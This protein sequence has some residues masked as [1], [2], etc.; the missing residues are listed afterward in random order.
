VGLRARSCSP[1][2]ALA[3]AARRCATRT[4]GSDRASIPL[5]AFD[6]RAIGCDS[7]FH[8]NRARSSSRLPRRI[9]TSFA[10]LFVRCLRLARLPRERLEV[11]FARSTGVRC[12]FV[13]LTLRPLMSRHARA[14]AICFFPRAKTRSS[15]KT[16]GERASERASERPIA[17]PSV[18]YANARR[19]IFNS[20]ANVNSLAKG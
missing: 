12:I 4:S 20:L 5:S 18:R 1:A 15:Q 11:A 9:V 7:E 8:A 2:R 14:I 16:V 13:R 19:L 6:R 10:L 17:R 3:S